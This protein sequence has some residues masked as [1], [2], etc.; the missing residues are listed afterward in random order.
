MNDCEK[1]WKNYFIFVLLYLMQFTVIQIMYYLKDI[2]PARGRLN[3]A[4]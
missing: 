4:F 3:V 1:E 2:E